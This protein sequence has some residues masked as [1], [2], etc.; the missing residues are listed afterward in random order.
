MNDDEFRWKLASDSVHLVL[1]WAACISLHSNGRYGSVL[2]G[3]SERKN[4]NNKVI[5]AE[6]CSLSKEG[7]LDCRSSCGRTE[8][9]SVWMSRW[10]NYT[11]KELFFVACKSERIRGHPTNDWPRMGKYWR[12]SK[13]CQYLGHK[14]PPTSVKSRDVINPAMAKE[15]F[16]LLIYLADRLT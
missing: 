14:E 15:V 12:P 13:L 6:A 2:T 7:L 11:S 10:C 9:V 8:T 16:Q 3:V 1:W 4:R 5:M